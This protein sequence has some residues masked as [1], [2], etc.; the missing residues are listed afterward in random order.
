MR[1]SLLAVAML[2]G[3]CG[4][5]A[6]QTADAAVGDGPAPDMAP[7]AVTWRN[8]PS[9]VPAV[10]FGGTAADGT[11]YCKYTIT[12]KQVDLQ[13][14]MLPSGQVTSGHIQDL[15]VEAVVPSMPPTTP[16]VCSETNPGSIPANI[17]MYQLA[18]ATAGTG[19]MTLTFQG[20]AS[21]APPASLVVVLTKV[22]SLYSAKLTFH[23]ND[24]IDPIFEWTVT[25]T[26][27]LAPQ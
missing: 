19:G 5:V 8:Q 21:N 3:A 24:G 22:S 7:G 23:R 16:F 20:G 11:Q 26:V 27:P 14:T 17:A 6:N 10:T 13:L 2:A 18:T 15:N 9:D 4:T 12:L 25:A 1:Y